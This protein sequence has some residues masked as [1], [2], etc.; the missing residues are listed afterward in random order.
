MSWQIPLL[1]RYIFAEILRVFLFVVSC[2]TLLLVVVG[3][4]QSASD[5]GLGPAQIL[6]VLPFIVPS[7][8]PFTIPAAMLLTVCVV[9]GRISGDQEVTACKAAGISV[10]SLLWPA[11]FLGAVLSA[12]SLLLTD[13]VIPWAIGNIERRIVT[14]MEDVVLDKLRA[15]HQFRD[16]KLGIDVT[17]RDVR[18][19]E[20]IRPIFRYRKGHSQAGTIQAESA[21]FRLDLANEKAILK[22]RNAY[23]DVPGR[24]AMYINGETERDIEWK[25]ASSGPKARHMPIQVIEQELA[26]ARAERETLLEEDAVQVAMALTTGD[27][28]ALGAGSLRSTAR[29]SVGGQPHPS[30]NDGDSCAICVGL[31]LLLLH[32][33]G[34]AIRGAAGED[35]VPDEFSVL[36]RPDHHRVLPVGADDDGAIQ[37]REGRPGLGD[38]GR[39]RGSTGGGVLRDSARDAETRREQVRYSALAVEPVDFPRRSSE[40]GEVS[41]HAGQQA[42]VLI[43]DFCP[44]QHFAV[45][46]V[47]LA[48][49]KDDAPG[50]LDGLLVVVDGDGEPDFGLFDALGQ[51][52]DTDEAFDP[53]TVEPQDA[54]DRLARFDPFAALPVNLDHDTVE[55]REDASPLQ[56]E[57]GDL[58][59]VPLD[60]GLHLGHVKFGLGPGDFQVRR[61]NGPTP[62]RAA[63]PGRHPV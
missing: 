7:M 4:V 17:V 44:D 30:A 41:L 42:E 39:Q 31:Q 50:G 54:E 48:A 62:D 29:S 33:V 43:G 24:G 23:I 21:E 47:N 8:L 1:Q 52:F 57:S 45:D 32:A 15:D 5:Q 2:L 13:Q 3:V 60:A 12:A 53:E 18:G 28:N 25:R 36:L 61:T 49:N 26:N 20:L 27:F 22:L 37:E 40:D 56:V 6:E 35:A 38:V 63:P 16:P 14:A 11:F 55:R 58:Q 9:Y 59:F 51:V 46:R 19:R 10:I 34:G